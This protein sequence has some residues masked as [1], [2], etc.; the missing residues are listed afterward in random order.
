MRV[1]YHLNDSG[2][3]LPLILILVAAFAV[4]GLGLATMSNDEMK[5]VRNFEHS[6]RA[7]YYAEGALNE[8]MAGYKHTGNLGR[9]EY[10]PAPDVARVTGVAFVE[11]GQGIC[12]IWATGR[13]QDVTK[14]V[15]MTVQR[16]NDALV[17]SQWKD[18][19][20]NERAPEL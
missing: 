2:I 12:T 5:L 17:V 7:F 8:A 6:V 10:R 9:Y 18:Y 15:V 20:L 19:G 14:H 4:L 3:A 1:K 16:Q 13:S 11:N